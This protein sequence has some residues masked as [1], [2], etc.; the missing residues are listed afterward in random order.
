MTDY[1]VDF[2]QSINAAIKLKVDGTNDVIVGGVNKLKPYGITNQVND[3]NEFRKPFTA[4]YVSVGDLG[5][6]T[7]GGNDLSD[8]AGQAIIRGYC[9][10]KEKVNDVR[11]YKNTTDFFMPDLGNDPESS[12]QF[13][14]HDVS[15][16]DVNGVYEFTGEAVLN[17]APA[18]FNIHH[19]SSTMVITGVPVTGDT[20]EDA[21]SGTFVTDGVL[22]GDTVILE[23]VTESADDY[24][25]HVV[26]AVTE[27]LITLDALDELTDQLTGSEFVIHI[28]R[29]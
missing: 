12:V 14:K 24:T 27:T 15:E 21:T 22:V 28:G 9:L 10:S 4:K 1:G 26:T 29:F 2:E 19:T 11:F 8:D 16:A 7:Y 18:T 13:S 5:T 17:G 6:I 25:Q 20:I 23:G 3:V